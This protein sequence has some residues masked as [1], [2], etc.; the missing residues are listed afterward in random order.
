MAIAI[1]LT[2]AWR[3]VCGHE[4]VVKLV[5]ISGNV[6]HEALKG[7]EL[8]EVEL[9]AW[10]CRPALVRLRETLVVPQMHDQMAHVVANLEHLLPPLALIVPQQVAHFVVVLT[11]AREFRHPLLFL[12]AISYWLV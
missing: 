5:D 12:V 9:D 1:L 7:Q 10:V 4:F 8:A 2:D 11:L 6:R 3:E